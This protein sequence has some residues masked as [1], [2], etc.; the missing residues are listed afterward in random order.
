MGLW[1]KKNASNLPL[2]LTDNSRYFDSST[3]ISFTRKSTVGGT[4][5]LIMEGD[6]E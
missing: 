4:S 6:I 2:K 1:G 3:K 5:G